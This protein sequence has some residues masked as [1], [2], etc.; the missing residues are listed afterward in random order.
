MR[1]AL[2]VA[3]F[4]V[5]LPLAASAQILDAGASLSLAHRHYWD[6]RNDCC[7]GSV[8]LTLGSERRWGLHLA[9][10]RSSRLSKGDSGYPHDELDDGRRDI[11]LRDDITQETMYEGHVLAA[12]H[13]VV[14]P[15]F[16]VRVLF[17][18]AVHRSRQ[19]RCV[20]FAGPSVRIPN[21]DGYGH[22]RFVFRVELTDEDLQRC[23]ATRLS[24]GRI[25]PMAGVAVDFPITSR[26]FIRAE[27]GL[28]AR[29]GVG[30]G[31][32]F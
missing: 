13:A 29:V 11:T 2:P 4:V 7:P 19:T 3:V 15:D 14:R 5:L 25:N 31:V 6:V 23:A 17:G 27:A 28:L 32:R 16:K 24:L 30:A 22:A 12:W 10:L 20:A 9:L 21:P 8:W 1:Y 26:F 18:A